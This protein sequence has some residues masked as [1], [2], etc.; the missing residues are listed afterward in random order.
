MYVSSKR[1]VPV[2]VKFV[3]E[4]LAN[5]ALVIV[6]FVEL[7]LV[8]AAVTAVNRFVKKL[9]VVAFVIDAFTPLI[10]F[11]AK[12]PGTVRLLIVVEA[13]VEE[14]D[15]VRLVKNPVTNAAML[16]K[17]LVTEVEANVEDP[18]TTKFA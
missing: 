10:V 2:A 6:A 16:P 17:I 12:L 13:S 15:T 1:V 7:I 4:A 14:P 9:V 3:I 5:C 18:V 8:N 11:P